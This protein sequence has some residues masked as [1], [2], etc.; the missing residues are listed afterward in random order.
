[1]NDRYSGC[2]TGARDATGI[3]GILYRWNRAT[4][5]GNRERLHFCKEL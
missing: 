2:F 4:S 1:M 3:S 5:Q